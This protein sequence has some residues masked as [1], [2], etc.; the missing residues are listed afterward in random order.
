MSLYYSNEKNIQLIVALLKAHNIRKVIASPGTTNITFIGSLMH[1]PFFEIYSSVD[2][3]SAAYI[4]CG[5][6]EESGEPIV[7]SCTG[8]TASRNYFSGLTEAYYRK[9]PILAITSTRE[10]CKIGHL[11]D[12]QIDRSRQ[13]KDTCVCSEHLQLIKDENDMW[14]CTI[15]INRAILA[16]RQHGGGPV[17]INLPTTYS[18]DFSVTKLPIVRKI[19]RYY[20]YDKLPEI[21][22]KKIAIFIGTHKKMTIQEQQAID[23]FCESFN[24]AVFKDSCSG[25]HGKYGLNYGLL[26]KDSGFDMDLL[27]HIGEVSAAAYSCRPKEVWRVSEDGELRDTFRKLT[28]VF[29]MSETYF[30]ESYSC[31]KPKIE[32][33]YFQECYEKY[34]QVQSNIL[35]SPF[36]N[37]W[38]SNYLRDKLPLNSALHLGIVSSFFAWNRYKLDDSIDVNCNQG[39]FGIDGIMSSLLGASLV[40]PQRLY[41]CVLGDLA[42][43]YDMNV[44]GNRHIGKNLRIL[45]I[46]N[47]DGVIFRK[48]NNIGSIFGEETPL[49]MSAGGHFGKKNI[50]LVKSYS[51]NLGF[52]YISASSKEEFI[53]KAEKFITPSLTEKSIIFEVFIDTQNEILGEKNI[54]ASGF[55][56]KIQS[57]IGQDKYQK[58]KE[59]LK[60]LPKGSM[61]V[62]KSGSN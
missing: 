26:S 43:F 30:F 19:S 2:E 56:R 7:L 3:R 39:G 10:E 24:A 59:I 29:E 60:P 57:L 50:D 14:D 54:P 36:S 41:F 61:T 28:N 62:D 4:A 42:F 47:G 33:S 22:Q 55:K 1:D 21:K 51:E 40:N 52:E 38:I 13:P 25:Y 31:G 48:P 17:H 15:K 12:Q 18:K 27:I 20:F 44:L 23:S 58:I 6:A 11:I 46:N 53:N 37:N 45:L 16:L 49:Y 34:M 35:D 5:M 8:A 32:T 9:L